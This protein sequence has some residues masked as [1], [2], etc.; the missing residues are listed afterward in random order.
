MLGSENEGTKMEL[1]PSRAAIARQVG[2]SEVGKPGRPGWEEPMAAG[3]VVTEVIQPYQR[4]GR[5]APER[6]RVSRHRPQGC[7]CRE[8]EEELWAC[9]KRRQPSEHPGWAKDV[10]AALGLL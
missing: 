5:R 2:V 6:R 8:S 7:R 9:P 1:S 4:V 10:A 3:L